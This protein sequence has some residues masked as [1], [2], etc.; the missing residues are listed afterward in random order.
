MA[1]KI[2]DGSDSGDSVRGMFEPGDP[3]HKEML[4]LADLAVR[5]HLEVAMLDEHVPVEAG[6][7]RRHALDVAD[8]RPRSLLQRG[9]EFVPRRPVRED[10]E[11]PLGVAPG[12]GLDVLREHGADLPLARLAVSGGVGGPAAGGGHRSVPFRGAP[13]G[14]CMGMSKSAVVDR[15]R[16]VHD[17]SRPRRQ[18]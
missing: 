18:A 9:R 11:D 17:S 8:H 13:A 16:V 3:R 6:Q 15:H 14:A 4:R 2:A 10:G 5:G 12:M 1:G 7:P